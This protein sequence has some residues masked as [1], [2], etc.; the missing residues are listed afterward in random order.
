MS[1]IK[2]LF[3]TKKQPSWATARDAVEYD[4]LCA[5][6]GGSDNSFEEC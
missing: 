1:I 2:K 5:L 3:P 6:F 4:K